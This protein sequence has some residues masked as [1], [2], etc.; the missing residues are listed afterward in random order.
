MRKGI[1][2]IAIIITSILLC[3]CAGKGNH[4]FEDSTPFN[5]EVSDS[6]EP[7]SDGNDLTFDDSD[8]ALDDSDEDEEDYIYPGPY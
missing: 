6:V 5:S 3:G 4:S 2:I 8:S 1:A 7:S